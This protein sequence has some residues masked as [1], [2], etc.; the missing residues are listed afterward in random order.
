MKAGGRFSLL[1]T[2]L[3]LQLPRLTSLPTISTDLSDPHQTQ[4]LFLWF[5]QQ[6]F[7]CNF[8]NP[9]IWM[10][11]V[12]SVTRCYTCKNKYFCQNHVKKETYIDYCHQQISYDYFK[13]N[14]ILYTLGKFPQLLVVPSENFYLNK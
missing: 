4:L 5:C 12:E 9:V 13:C 2:C 6:L 11:C 1:S 14:F 10:D 3:F 8:T 7:N